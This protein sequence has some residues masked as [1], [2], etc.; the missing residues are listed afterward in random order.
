MLEGSLRINTS[1][2]R[3][4][5]ERRTFSRRV[6]YS[7]GLN[8]VVRLHRRTSWGWISNRNWRVIPKETDGS[9]RRMS[10]QKLSLHY[11]QRIQRKQRGK[12]VLPEVAISWI[13]SRLPIGQLLIPSLLAWRCRT[14]ADQPVLKG[15]VQRI[16]DWGFC[17]SNALIRKENPEPRMRMFSSSKGRGRH[18][19]LDVV[20][21][22]VI[23]SVKFRWPVCWPQDTSVSGT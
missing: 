6:W 20:S 9:F 12:G 5:I 16:A 21:D 14:Y 4:S 3:D 2:D 15:I 8:A 7:S 22:P 13:W 1:N 11:L 17:Q 23:S 10:H 18:P 19:N